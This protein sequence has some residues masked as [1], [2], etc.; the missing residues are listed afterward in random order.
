MRIVLRRAIPLLICVTVFCGCSTRTILI[1]S[2][3]PVQIRH[4]VEA[5]VWVFDKDGK[6]VERRVIIPEG[7]YALEDK[8]R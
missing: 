8:P 2:G 7:W 1:P 3:M 6:K 5:D 4:P